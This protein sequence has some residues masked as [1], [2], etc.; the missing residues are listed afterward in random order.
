MENPSL[1][2]VIAIAH[3]L[4]VL[5]EF[6]TIFQF[7][8]YKDTLLERI[9]KNVIHTLIYDKVPKIVVV[10]SNLEH[11]LVEKKFPKRSDNKF[12]EYDLL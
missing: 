6:R 4:Q 12:I 10:H 3:I 9:L 2:F 7:I 1:I 5:F 11:V 8:Q